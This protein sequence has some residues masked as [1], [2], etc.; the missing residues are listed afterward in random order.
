VQENP[1]FNFYQPMHTAPPP[2][3]LHPR[4]QQVFISSWLPRWTQRHLQGI[5]PAEDALALALE[6]L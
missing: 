4:I 3:P 1:R 5:S 6:T 2:H